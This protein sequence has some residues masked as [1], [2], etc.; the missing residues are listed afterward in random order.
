VEST[1]EKPGEETIKVIVESLL[2]VAGGPV[3]EETL[4]HTLEV[5]EGIIAGVLT[6]LEQETAG[7]GIRLQRQG[8]AAQ[9]V[10]APQAATYVEKF[11]GLQLSGRL[12]PA[13]LETLAIVAYRQPVTRAQVEALRGVN[14]DGVLNT[15][16]SR[17]LIEETGR[18]ETAGRPILYGTTFE[19]LKAFGLNSLAD[20][21]A[22]ALPAEPPATETAKPPDHSL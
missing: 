10:T 7:R 3:S 5:E 6:Q 22:L 15:L 2:F 8:K 17:G 18:L 9:W 21:P 1:P 14:S 16:V 11:L 12:S 19:F 13:A 20:L 4:A